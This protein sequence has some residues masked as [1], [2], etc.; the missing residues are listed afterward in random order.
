MK[1]E[2]NQTLHQLNEAVAQH[3]SSLP[4]KRNMHKM[5]S[6][7]EALTCRLQ[8][9]M[10]KGVR[11][12]IS[13]H[14]LMVPTHLLAISVF[15]LGS[16]IKD[17]PL[18]RHLCSTGTATQEQSLSKFPADIAISKDQLNEVCR[19]SHGT[20]AACLRHL[21]AITYSCVLLEHDD[22]MAEW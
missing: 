13:R 3:H 22:M 9:A 20:S 15:S 6:E 4:D 8:A 14:M 19:C 5:T 21:L 18:K 10:R 7:L 16:A 11:M 2:L 1:K 17:S 12:S